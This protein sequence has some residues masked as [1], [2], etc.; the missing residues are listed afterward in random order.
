MQSWRRTA[1]IPK[2]KKVGSAIWW[3]CDSDGL[4]ASDDLALRVFNRMWLE[5]N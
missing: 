1:P 4:W 5:T 3:K 2:R